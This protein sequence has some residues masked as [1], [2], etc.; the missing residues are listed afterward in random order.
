[1]QMY[2]RNVTVQN[3]YPF[4]IMMSPWLQRIFFTG[5]PAIFAQLFL[6]FVAIVTLLYYN[7]YLAVFEIL[8]SVITSGIPILVNRHGAEK[9]KAYA[10]ALGIYNTQIKD[11]ISAG[12]VL[13]SCH[14]ED[15]I[16][17][18]HS[19]INSKVQEAYVQIEKERGIVYAVITATRYMEGALFLVFGSYLIATG[20]LSVAA[21]LDAMQIVGYVA[22]PVKQSTTLYANYKRTHLVIEGIR[23]FIQEIE[24]AEEEKEEL[25][26]PT[27]IAIK[28]LSFSYGDRRIFEGRFRTV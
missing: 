28:H 7:A 22:N 4:L 13:K 27:P 17:K 6:A 5:V 9:Q 11:Y 25:L 18:V 8:L 24:G 19:E 23:K 12:D 3:I 16:Q 2:I 26:S 1:M 14:V 10:D 15:K 21:M 20:R